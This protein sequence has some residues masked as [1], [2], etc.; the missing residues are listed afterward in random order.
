MTL[1]S[2][3]PIYWPSINLNIFFSYFAVISTVVVIYDWILAF[4]HEVE[5]IW[6][7]PWSLI[8]VLYVGVRYAG[9]PYAV[10]NM[11]DNLPTVSVTDAVSANFYYAINWISVVMNVILGAIMIIRLHA[12]YQGSRKM[13]IFLIV[14]LLPVVITSGVSVGFTNSYTSGEELVLSGTYKCGYEFGGNSSLLLFITWILGTVWEV[15]MF[16]LVVWIAVKHFREL[17]RWTIEGFY[18][19]LIKTHVL[20]FA[21]CAAVSCFQFGYYSPALA[22]SPIG[23]LVYGGVLQILWNVQ[24]FVLGPRLILSVREFNAKLVA[25][26]EAETNMTAIDFQ[27]H[28]RMSIGSMT[29]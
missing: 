12:L 17:R 26:F 11:L 28:T 3:D 4:G 20:Y 10:I 2:N 27:E 24:M 7:R 14:T 18:T 8:T 16:C 25:G 15:L 19:V 13:L 22:T 21:S 5:L 1:V 29:A 9:M 6:R 23:S